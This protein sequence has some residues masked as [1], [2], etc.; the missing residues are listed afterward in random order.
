MFFHFHEPLGFLNAANDPYD[1]FG[2][3]SKQFE[4]LGEY[5]SAFLYGLTY[6]GDYGGDSLSRYHFDTVLENAGHLVSVVEGN[7]GQGL[8][9]YHVRFGTDALAPDARE[10]FAG[11]FKFLAEFFRWALTERHD[12]PVWDDSDYSDWEWNKAQEVLAEDVS[13]WL[14][15]DIRSQFSSSR[16]LADSDLEF[17]D[18]DILGAIDSLYEKYGE[19]P[20][21]EDA[22]S[23]R[24]PFDS[25][26]I[27]M[28]IL[29]NYAASLN[30]GQDEALF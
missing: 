18:E 22:V 6:W 27:A 14:G 25:Q 21:F 26:D 2:T 9:L 17:S 10:Q 23:I 3:R 7:Y 20:S 19:Y 15:S 11:E 4:S 1:P 29:E 28:Q 5:A 8:V 16:G 12:Y 30:P 13:G 24:I